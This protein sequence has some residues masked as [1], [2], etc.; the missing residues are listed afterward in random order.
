[1]IGIFQLQKSLTLQAETN[2]AELQLSNLQTQY[3]NYKLAID[4]ILL[5][6][7]EGNVLYRF[8]ENPEDIYRNRV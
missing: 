5:A 8:L 3:L 4:N 2:R 7:R 6:I 1:M